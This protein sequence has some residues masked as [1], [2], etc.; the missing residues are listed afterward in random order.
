M[1]KSRGFTICECCK[2]KIPVG[3]RYLVVHGR[4]WRMDHIKT[5]EAHRQTMKG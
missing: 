2:G 3:T 4:P 1:P 5:Y